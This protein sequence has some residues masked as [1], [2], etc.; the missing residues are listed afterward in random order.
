MISLAGELP[1]LN[2]FI[3]FLSSQLQALHLQMIQDGYQPIQMPLPSI[4]IQPEPLP[5]H[6]VPEPR[7]TGL[8]QP[9]INPKPQIPNDREQALG[10]SLYT[11]PLPQ[12]EAARA[13][14][15]PV[16]KQLDPNCLRGEC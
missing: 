13:V 15:A 6:S 1:L 11:L 2:L 16:P 9:V 8:S 5:E 3:Q 7:T 4:C 12:Q 14:I 10:P